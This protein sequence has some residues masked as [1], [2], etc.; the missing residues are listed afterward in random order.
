APC[1]GSR[2]SF[3]GLPGGNFCGQ[4]IDLLPG[5]SV[6]VWV[7]PWC[8]LGEARQRVPCATAFLTRSTLVRM[9]LLLRAATG[10]GGLGLPRAAKGITASGQNMCVVAEAIEQRGGELFVA[11]HLDPLGERQV[12]GDDG[13]AALVA[14]GQQ[15]EQ[16]LAASALKRNE[17]EF[18]HD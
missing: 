1:P 17:A 2:K 4:L 10:S 15:I 9:G 7:F 11:E 13:G 5:T 12:G 16:Q 8:A 6:I 14:L 3:L 18:V